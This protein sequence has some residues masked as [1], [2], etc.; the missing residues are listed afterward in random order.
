MRAGSSNPVE[1]VELPGAHHTFDLWES[2]R[3]HAIRTAVERFIMN[4]DRAG[5]GDPG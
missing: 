2:I 4:V 1:Y 5:A 3:S